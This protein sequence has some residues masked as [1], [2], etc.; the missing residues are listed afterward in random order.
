[1]RIELWKQDAA[2]SLQASLRRGI[3]ILIA[4]QLGVRT[5]TREHAYAHSG[6]VFQCVHD[7]RKVRRDALALAKH[8]AP[9]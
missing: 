4:I 2:E 3:T 7:P 6:H 1:M 9:C 5:H 8:G